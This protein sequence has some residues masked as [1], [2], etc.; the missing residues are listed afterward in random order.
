M[1]VEHALS[2]VPGFS[3]RN[4]KMSLHLDDGNAVVTCFSCEPVIRLEYVDII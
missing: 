4:G 1:C 3:F 2:L